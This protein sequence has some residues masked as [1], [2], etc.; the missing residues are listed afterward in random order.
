[1][2]DPASLPAAESVRVA[3]RHMRG[4]HGPEHMLF[5]FWSALADMLESAALTAPSHRSRG[6]LRAGTWS[7]VCLD[8][9]PTDAVRAARAYLAAVDGRCHCELCRNDAGEQK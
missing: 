3:V 8:C 6:A 1:M 7:C 2:T 5:V 4:H 9:R